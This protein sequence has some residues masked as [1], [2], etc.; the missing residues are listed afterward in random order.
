MTNKKILAIS[1][2]EL[3]SSLIAM[4]FFKLVVLNSLLQLF[5]VLGS[6]KAMVIFTLEVN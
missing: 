3:N 1:S 2:M 5:L 6:L 4:I